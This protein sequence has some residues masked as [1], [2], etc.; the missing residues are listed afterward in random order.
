MGISRS[1]TSGFQIR[2]TNRTLLLVLVLSVLGCAEVTKSQ[3]RGSNFPG[4]AIREGNR[5]MDDYDRDIN[6][7]KNDAKKVNE[8][9]RNL[10]PQINEDFQQIQIIHNEIVR[11]LKPDKELDY[12]RLSDLTGDMKKRGIRLREN[13]ALPEPDQSTSPPHNENIDDALLRSSIAELHELVVSFVASPIFKNLGVVDT[14]VINAARVNLDN[15]I[16]TSEQI[17]RDAKS[18]SKSAKVR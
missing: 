12:E 7:M 18:L 10:F 6:R 4:P 15:I 9:R 3:T 8:R 2:C 1:Q 11:L 14:K 5:S 17:K 16:T 13:L